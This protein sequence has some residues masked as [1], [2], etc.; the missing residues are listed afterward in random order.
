MAFAEILQ[1]DPEVIG[2]LK[3]DIQRRQTPCYISVSATNECTKKLAFSENFFDR[4]FRTFA[5]GYFDHCRQQQGKNPNDPI[6]EDDFRIFAN[7]FDNLRK[8]MSPVLQKP[9]RELKK[10]MILS[11][12]QMLRQKVRTD[13]NSFLQGFVGQALILSAHL[14]IERVKYFVNQLGFF[15]T[16]NILPDPTITAKLMANIRSSTMR[17]P[18]H[19]EDAEN[20]S[21]AWAHKNKSGEKTVFVSIDFRTVIAYAEEV[22]RLIG[23]QCA[24]PLYAVHFI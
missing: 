11:V 4:V 16:N 8:T 22:L 5:Q 10:K 2:K 1:E 20:I 17:N 12:E 15:K 7:L 21:S 24:D 9:L 19:Q 18:F 3:L 13:L 14:R 6:S 23:L